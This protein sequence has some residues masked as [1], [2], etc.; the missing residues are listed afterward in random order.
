[1]QDV[2]SNASCTTN[3][4]APLVK[5]VHN[6]FGIKEV[7]AWAHLPPHV[8]P[9]VLKAFPALAPTC[10]GLCAGRHDGRVWAA[11]ADGAVGACMRMQGLMTTVHA[12]T[13][14]QKTVDGPSRKDW[15][16]GRAA[17]SN[18]IPSSTGAAKAVG[19]VC[20]AAAARPVLHACACLPSC[21]V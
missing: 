11:P 5:I 10:R 12:T 17:A 13:A 9:K 14:T 18:I 19:K 1:M 15:R 20:G 6:T 7:R 3:C 4:L 8:Y 16:G 21:S 2:I